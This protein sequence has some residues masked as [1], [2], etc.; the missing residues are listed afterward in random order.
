MLNFKSV[1]DRL[2]VLFVLL[3]AVS[4]L[5][6]GIYFI[7]SQIRSNDEQVESYKT[8]LSQQYDRELRIQTEGLI[9]AVEGL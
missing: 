4:T 7:G 2:T 1:R 3:S 5:V 6:V 8:K 9:S